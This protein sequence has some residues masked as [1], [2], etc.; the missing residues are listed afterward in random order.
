[1]HARR[2]LAEA[3][4]VMA[5]NRRVGTSVD[6]IGVTG[7]LVGDSISY[8]FRSALE[9]CASERAWVEFHEMIFTRVH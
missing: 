9:G 5:L 8:S 2:L 7:S 3:A 6:V 1:M 4:T